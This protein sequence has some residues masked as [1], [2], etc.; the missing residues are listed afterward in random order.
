MKKWRRESILDFYNLLLTGFMSPWRSLRAQR[1]PAGPKPAGFHWRLM[2]PR[3][4]ADELYFN[5]VLIDENWV[6]SEEPKPFTTVMMASAIPAAIRPYSIAV[7]PDSS[8]KNF[9]M[10]RFKPA[11]CSVV[12]KRFK[13]GEGTR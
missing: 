2:L 8:D 11:S 1:N 7:A 3:K 4:E 10:L 6:F 5:E 12:M 13:E 9:K